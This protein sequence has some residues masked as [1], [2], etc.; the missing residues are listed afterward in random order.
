[1]HQLVEG[2]RLRLGGVDIAHPKGLLGHS[3][4][5]V[6]LHAIA[7]AVLGA[8]GLP[9]IGEQFPDNDP[10]YKDADSRGLLRT[11][12]GTVTGAGFV[13]VNVD[14]VVHA[15]EPKLKPFK[16]QMAE[17][18]A[19]ILGLTPDRVCVKATT[20][21]RLGPIGRGEGIA[22]TAVVLMTRTA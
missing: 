20:N 19:E 2:R 12:M 10:A 13:P 17:C 14:C 7:D 9:D 21:E 18:I 8:A 3:D 16:R 5:D 22:C 15:E 6:V 1:M 4:S 11:I